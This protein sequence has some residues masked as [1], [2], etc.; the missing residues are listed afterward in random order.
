MHSIEPCSSFKIAA[1]HTKQHPLQ[2]I[3]REFQAAQACTALKPSSSTDSRLIHIWPPSSH[4]ATWAAQSCTALCPTAEQTV[5][6]HPD[7]QL[8]KL[9]QLPWSS[10]QPASAGDMPFWAAAISPSHRVTLPP[11]RRLGQAARTSPQVSTPQM[12]CRDSSGMT[13]VSSPAISCTATCPSSSS[14]STCRL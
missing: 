4:G 5:A 3:K 13:T 7:K 6:S 8:D 10:L 14:S 2:C 12:G 11:G 9:P 1:P